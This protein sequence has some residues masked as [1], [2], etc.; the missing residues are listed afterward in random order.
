MPNRMDLQDLA[1]LTL[2]IGDLY[3]A[4]YLFRALLFP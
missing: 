2:A 4:T 1:I 3:C